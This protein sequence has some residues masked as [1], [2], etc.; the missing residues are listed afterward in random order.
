MANNSI[1]HLNYE[2]VLNQGKA[3]EMMNY[4]TKI[5]KKLAL[6][7]KWKRYFIKF[8]FRYGYGDFFSDLNIEINTYCNRRC[9][10]CPNSIYDRGLKENEK[11]MDTNL[12]YKIVD[13]L[14]EINFKGRISP[15]C[16]GEPLMDE[17]LP[18]LMEYTRKKL[19]KVKLVVISNGDALTVDKF[20]QLI[21]SGVDKFTITQHGKS[22]SPNM[23]KIFE[24]LEEHPEKKKK[25][26][27]DSFSDDTPLYNRG[28]LIKPKV[29]NTDPRCANPANPLC[30]DSDGNVIL[31]C[32][33]YFS[34]VKF[35][36]LADQK[37]LDIWFSKKYKNLRAKLRKKE[38]QLPICLKCTGK[39]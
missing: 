29:V 25:I 36:N 21:N 30:I 8:Y 22:M 6:Y 3:V 19:P 4:L 14:S 27:Y 39:L 15:Q 35:G 2:F 33:D 1:T 16:Y 10:Y 17:R 11:F 18:E 24:Y 13:E 28:G 9:S 23:K 12:Y 5:K 32:H 38:F 31:C 20:N 34:S 7:L 26:K 37:L